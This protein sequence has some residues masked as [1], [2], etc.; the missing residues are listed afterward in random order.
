MGEVAEPNLAEAMSIPAG[1]VNLILWASIRSGNSVSKCCCIDGDRC[2]IL[3]NGNSVGIDGASARIVEH[4]HAYVIFA[5]L[6]NERRHRGASVGQRRLKP[7]SDI[8]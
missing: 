7:P 3:H 8:E 2:C 4:G 6:G 1:I 5:R